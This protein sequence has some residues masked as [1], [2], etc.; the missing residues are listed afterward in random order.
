MLHQGNAETP[1]AL[2]L[3]SPHLCAPTDELLQITF[4]LLISVTGIAR[5]R[6]HSTPR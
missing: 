4:D 1:D 2:V 5:R 3:A 6:H